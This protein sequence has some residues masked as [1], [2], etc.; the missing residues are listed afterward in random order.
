MIEL[1]S[2]R[3]L[4]LDHGLFFPLATRLARDFGTVG[5]HCHGWKRG[6]PSYH[7]HDIGDGFENIERV[8]HLWDDIDNFDLLVFPDVLDGDLQEYLRKRG[9]RVF[10]S[11]KGE[12]LELYRQFGK[13]TL[14][15]VGL[16]VQPY[17]VVEGVAAL[18]TYL[19]AHKNKYVKLSLLRGVMET[20]HHDEYWITEPRLDELEHQLGI[21]KENTKFLI[22]DPIETEI[23]YG[24]DGIC[25]DGQFPKKA[26]LG[27]E[28]KDECFVGVVLD[29]D[30]L[31]A[32]A[33]E[34]NEVLAPLLKRYSYRNFFSTEIRETADGTPYLIDPCCRQPSPSGE[35][36]QEL[37]GNLAEMIWMGAEGVLV[38]PEPKAKFAVESII[39]GDR[40]DDNWQPIKI[41]D[42][43]RDNVKLF[44]HTRV[45]GHDYVIP[46]STKQ[47]EVGAVVTIGDN[48]EQTIAENEAIANQIG[49]DKIEVRTKAIAN[50]VKE[51]E[52][53]YKEKI[54]STNVVS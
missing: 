11:G 40:A 48:L 14:E 29:Y 9:Y 39:Y 36:Q 42:K 10:G 34:V 54:I 32:G 4:I 26:M 5:Y 46:Q 23:E 6:F 18:R 44:F 27:V 33:V 16:P 7:E 17:R 25:I 52:T 35:A 20:F 8:Q 47:N 43:Y 50:A 31:P 30:D 28:C 2:K 22:E 41:P 49:G 21:R 38:E 51:F 24:F 12:E 37:W 1:K 19:K 53:M 3:A 45:N 15:E 13:E